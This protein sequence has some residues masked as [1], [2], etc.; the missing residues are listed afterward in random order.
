MIDAGI[1]RDWRNRIPIVASP[2]KIV[3]VTGYR[4]DE[5]VKITPE[6]TSV[7]RLKFVRK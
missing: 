1:P 2:D 6:T 4:I 5:R 7:L 3:W